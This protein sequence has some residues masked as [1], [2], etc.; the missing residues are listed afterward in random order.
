M[1]N[2]CARSAT[3][4]PTRP[5]P[6]TPS[7]LPS[8]CVPVNLVRSHL[9]AL[10]LSL[11]LGTFRASER[12][13]AIVCSAVEI[14]LPPGVFITTMPRRRGGR[15]VDVVDAHARAHDRLQPRLAFENFGRELRARADRDSVGLHERLAQGRRDP[16]PAWC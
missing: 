8:S 16:G 3:A 7:V 10:R 2:P 13:K 14:V 11:A 5:R 4:S 9:P 15:D 1:P 12:S 6:I